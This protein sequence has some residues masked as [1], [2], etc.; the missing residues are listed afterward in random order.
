M[1]KRGLVEEVKSLLEAGVSPEAKVFN[2]HGYRRVV[3]YLKGQRTLAN[4][5][6]QMK[7]DT[8]HYAKRQL[9]WWRKQPNAFWLEGFGFSES[10]I[11]Q[12]SRIV[13]QLKN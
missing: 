4:A 6:E 5:L 1:L 8:R 13:A 3:E 11:E 10:I 7:L 12:A 2:A 9:T